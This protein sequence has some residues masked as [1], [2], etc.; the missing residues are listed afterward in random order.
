MQEQNRNERHRSIYDHLVRQVSTLLSAWE[1]YKSIYHDDPETRGL[2]SR[3][4]H[5]FFSFT[6]AVYGYHLVLGISKLLDPAKIHGN[7]N[8]V[9]AQLFPSPDV[10]PKDRIKKLEDRLHQ[11]EQNRSQAGENASDSLLSE[12]ETTTTYLSHAR[13][14]ERIHDMASPIRQARH[15]YIAHQDL[16]RCFNSDEIRDFTLGVKHDD[17]HDVLASIIQFLKKFGKIHHKHALVGFHLELSSRDHK[18]RGLV[19]SLR[20]AE[21]YERLVEDSD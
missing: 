8:L 9:L 20:K 21:A 13:H 12:I 19:N 1:L 6:Y 10:S 4:D 3:S 11:L 15:K 14:L 18:D 5:R 2:L 7:D 17:I 16:A